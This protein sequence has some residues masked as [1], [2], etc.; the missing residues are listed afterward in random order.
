MSLAGS[1]AWPASRA[2]Y[3]GRQVQTPRTHHELRGEESSGPY[4]LTR[5][6]VTA[7]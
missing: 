7:I 4:A 1:E 5:V 6:E 3:K 2:Q